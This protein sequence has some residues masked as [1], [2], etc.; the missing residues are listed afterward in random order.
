[1]ISPHQQFKKGIGVLLHPT[2]LPGSPVCGTFGA[3]ARL[4]LNTL[5]KNGIGFWQILPL[6]P[7]DSFGSPYSSPSSFAFN[8]W[9]LDAEDLVEEGFLSESFL[10][11]LPGQLED[12]HEKV[13]FELANAR[14]DL[15]GTF[16]RKE[17]YKQNQS[18]KKEFNYWCR[19]QFWLEDHVNFME[20]R[21]Q[22][23]GLP[24]WNWSKS[25]SSSNYLL[26]SSWKIR[27]HDQ[28]L[29]HRL[30]Q[31]HL[32]R[33][34]KSIQDLAKKLG[35]T[36]FGDM[37]FY[38]SRDSADVWS[39]RSLFSIL[40]SG[41]LIKQSGV[42]PDYFSVT[43]QLWGT[44]VYLW[45]KHIK[46]NFRW[47]RRRTLRHLN[48]VNLLR[49]DHFRALDSYWEVSGS[50]KTAIEGE[51]K[52]SPG[53]DLL[54]LLKEDCNNKMQLIAEDLGIITEEVE[55]LRD[56][57][58]IPGMKILQFAF[59]GNEDNPYL[60]NN[61]K[62]HNWVVYSGTHDNSTTYSWW[63]SLSKEDKEIISKKINQGEDNPVWKI[64][65]TCLS[66]SAKLVIIP[67]Q[68][69]LELDNSARLNT[70]G[71][72][73]NNWSWRIDSRSRWHEGIKYY[74]DRG[75]FWKR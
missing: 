58:N 44:P 35:I 68:D 59:D 60:P 33:Q 55:T 40:N 22:N 71:T 6:G 65:D 8:T 70:P 36:L 32:Y 14:S 20:L 25:F 50:S 15:L 39:N 45:D 61:I 16:L 42:P 29:E 12:K 46:T 13:D 34:W 2:S 23:K 67:M 53:M 19:T 73:I 56:H 21:R 38:V 43:G 63:N 30:M 1:M 66:T 3:P 4:W 17:W 41:E 26:V 64:I 69:I 47:W 57:F 37:P 28:L 75:S 31:W 51:W 10:N 5:A 72:I 11:K 54:K 74:G 48:Q 18:T 27:F 24:W 52:K 7:P 62:G 9:F 49:L